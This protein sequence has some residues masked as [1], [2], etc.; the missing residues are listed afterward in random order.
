MTNVNVASY[1][2]NGL[3]NMSKRREIFN[4]LRTN[5]SDLILLQETHSSQ[6]DEVV[7][8]NEWG[9]QIIFSH[10]STAARGVAILFHRRL[11]ITVETVRTDLEGRYIIADIIIDKTKFVLV[12]M[13]APN[14]DDP[15][16]FVKLFGKIEE[17]NNPSLMIAGVFNTSIN[18]MIDLFNHQGTNH[19]KKRAIL[20]EYLE[21]K[22]LIDIWRVK[23]PDSQTFSWKKPNS[24]TLM[25]SR[26][27]YFLVSQ[28]LAMRTNAAHIKVK[29]KS[30]HSRVVLDMDF[31][32]TKRGKGF[33]KFNNLH[34]H[35]KQF[36]DIMNEEILKFTYAVKNKNEIGL[37]LQWENLKKLMI[38]VAKDYSKR[39]ALEKNKLI[40]K[41]ENRIIILDQKIIHETDPTKIQKHLDRIKKTEEF[42]MDKHEEKVQAARFHTKSDYYL[43]GEK[44]TAYFFNL[45]KARANSKNIT[46]LR[47]EL[48]ETIKNPQSILKEEQLFYK[49]LY[50]QKPVSQWPYQN[51]S[52]T[53]LSEEEKINLDKEMTDQEL[54]ASLA[55]MSNNKTPGT[56]GLS[57]DFYK[58]FWIHLKS[59]YGQVV[60][61]ALKDEILHPTAR[62]GII[63]LLPKKDKDLRLTVSQKLEALNLAKCRLQN[64]F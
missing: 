42:L 25:M 36:L 4:Y 13:Y 40:E 27:D 6:S 9:N 33:W 11:P 52:D 49:K 32:E 59:L 24:N 19:I 12:N 45:E 20:L 3:Q 29:Y 14:E 21:Q 2:V 46:A 7:W 1:N 58:V 34:L 39:K 43:Q 51:T 18:P 8:S 31:T 57:A 22:E 5:D 56:D 61:A 26:L 62:Q 16:F 53:K 28:D 60:R 17:R 38:S 63:T 50:N 55:G 30:D 64:Y 47:N 10:G 37:A 41:L 35:D 54:S 48:G 15:Q 23:H 44:N